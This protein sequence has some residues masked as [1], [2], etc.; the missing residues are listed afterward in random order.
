[1]SG[2]PL[3]DQAK[4]AI[5]SAV[6]AAIK[7]KRGAPMDRQQEGAGSPYAPVQP[8]SVAPPDW[9]SQRSRRH[10]FNSAEDPLGFSDPTHSEAESPADPSGERRQGSRESDPRAG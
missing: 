3:S 8:P 6:E 7:Q 2:A 9:L 1:M 5:H 4:V 10:I